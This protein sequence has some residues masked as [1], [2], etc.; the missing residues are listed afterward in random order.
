[1]L[2]EQT[3]TGVRINGGGTVVT[4]SFALVASEGPANV[5]W[6]ITENANAVLER[7]VGS[8]FA[9]DTNTGVAIHNG[10]RAELN[11][12]RATVFEGDAIGLHIFKEGVGE[13]KESTFKASSDTFSVAFLLEDGTSKAT[14]STFIADP[15]TIDHLNVFAVRLVGSSN[16]DSNQS[17]YDGSAFAAVNVGSGQG[18]FGASQLIGQVSGLGF[19][20]FQCIFAY[21]GNYTAR[22]A[23]CL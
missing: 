12:V 14:E 2:S 11:N 20:S 21:R 9:G 13:V 4:E 22:N 17:N 8:A 7:V 18:R 5:A 16:L 15:I 6:D 19:T 23:I 3:A 1:M 10:A